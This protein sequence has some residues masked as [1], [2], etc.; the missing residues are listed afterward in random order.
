M[1]CVDTNEIWIR[2]VLINFV[3]ILI[4]FLRVFC[5]LTVCALWKSQMIWRELAM[6]GRTEGRQFQHGKSNAYPQGG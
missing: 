2:M 6:T 1:Q 3:K 4:A 5:E